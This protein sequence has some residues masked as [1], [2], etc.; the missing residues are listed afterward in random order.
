MFEVD[1]QWIERLYQ[2]LY[3]A[4]SLEKEDLVIKLSKLEL[5][6]FKL[7]MEDIDWEE[8]NLIEEQL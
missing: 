8:L 6:F 3:K 5:K 4:K 2:C 1:R 7:Q